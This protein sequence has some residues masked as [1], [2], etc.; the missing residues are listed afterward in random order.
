[1]SMNF[2]TYPKIGRKNADLQ[3]AQNESE[4]DVYI[5]NYLSMCIINPLSINYTPVNVSF[6]K[7]ITSK[8]EPRETRSWI[9]QPY[10]KVEH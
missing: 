8:I 2:N 10:V 3:M 5:A 9:G 4:C 7:K 6:L 1:M